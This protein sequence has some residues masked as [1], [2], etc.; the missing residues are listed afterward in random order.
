MHSG[1][2]GNYTTTVKDPNNATMYAV[3]CDSS[4]IELS[5]LLAGTYT[6]LIDPSVALM[7][8]ITLT[9]Y[10]VPA[11][12]PPTTCRPIPLHH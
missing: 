10:D 11:D 6:I 8:T 2:L 5:L 1:S 3:C 9:A 4:W 12:P 7:G